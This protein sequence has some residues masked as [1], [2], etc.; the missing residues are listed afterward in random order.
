MF[1]K[2]FLIML[3]NVLKKDYP[4]VEVEFYL[5]RRSKFAHMGLD[6]PLTKI[7]N[8]EQLISDIE[9]YWENKKQDEK[10]VFCE[11]YLIHSAKW[12]FDYVIFK[13][14]F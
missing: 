11:P 4:N 10:F 2:T 7:E 8:Y 1:M 3:S 13:K 6:V 14:K 9:K 5:S 12:K